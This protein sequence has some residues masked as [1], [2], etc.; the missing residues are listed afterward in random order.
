MISFKI[1][2]FSSICEQSRYIF[3]NL[4]DRSLPACKAGI[5]IYDG[6]TLSKIVT[7]Q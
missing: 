7:A 1:M 4:Q 6:F 5:V 2:H 3:C